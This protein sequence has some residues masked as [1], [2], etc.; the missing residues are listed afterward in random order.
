MNKIAIVGRLLTENKGIDEIILYVNQHSNIKKIIICGHD[1]WGH[2][3]GH[4]L[5]QLHTNGI[6][7]KSRIIGSKSPDPILTVKKSE[8]NYFQ[9]E[10]KLINLIDEV[11]LKKISYFI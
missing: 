4:S 5:F 6:D 7:H 3:A 8:I 10:I 11:N 2:K 1:V 9:Q